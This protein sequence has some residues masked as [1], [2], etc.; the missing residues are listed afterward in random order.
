MTCGRRAPVGAGVIVGSGAEGPAVPDEQWLRAHRWVWNRSRLD[1]VLTQHEAPVFVC[2]IAVP[3][4]PRTWPRTY[5]RRRRADGWLHSYSS[6][7]CTEQGGGPQ[8]LEPLA[9][10]CASID[11]RQG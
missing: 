8:T 5:P 10:C 1:D 2:G 6:R 3:R 9:V 4:D 11:S 7:P